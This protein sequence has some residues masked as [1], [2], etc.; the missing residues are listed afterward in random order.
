ME[1]GFHQDEQPGLELLIFKKKFFLFYFIYLFFETESHSVPQAEMQWSSL[2]SLQPPPPRF[3]LF[4]CLSV[5][6]SWDYRGPAN[7]LYF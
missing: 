2:G 7:L 1:M 5:P 6:S 3:K 4:S